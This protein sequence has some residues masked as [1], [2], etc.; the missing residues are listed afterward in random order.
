M[1]EKFYQKSVEDTLKATLSSSQGLSE[2]E[3]KKR[4]EQ[5]GYNELE[6]IKSQSTFMIFLSQFKDLLVLILIAAAIV[7]MI[8]GELEST[9]VILVVITMNAILGTVQSVKAQKSLESLKQLSTPHT[10]VIRD[11]KTMEIS[12]KELSVG[13]IMLLEAGDVVGAD[14]RII[15]NYTLQVNE[16]A[17]TGEVESV[18][19]EV[20]AIEQECGLGDQKNMVFSSGL[21]TYGRAVCVVTGIGMDT[22][23][24]KIATLMNQTKERKTPLQLTLDDF[25]KKLSI[26]IIAICIL[27]FGLN[28]WQGDAILDALMFAVA[29]AVAAIP[30]ALASIVTIVL[31]MG[32]SQMA[33]ENAIVKNIN[34]VE[35]LGCVSVICSDKTGTL[36]QNK[37]TAQEIYRNHE[38]IKATALKE[39]TP[40]DRMM[41][42]GFAL[43]TDAQTNEQQR[44]GDPTELAL[45]DL[46]EI[47]HID[48]LTTRKKYERIDENPFDSQRKLMSTLQMIDGNATLLLKGACDEILK[49]S[50]KIHLED[51]IHDITEEDKVA[52][53]QKNEAFA[54]NGLRV[55]GFAY[56]NVNHQSISIEDEQELIFIGLISLMDPPRVESKTA[57]EHCLRAGI[58]PIMI[59][60]DHKVTAR[61]IAKTLGIYQQGDLCLEGIEL[62]AMSEEELDEKLASIKVYA[63]VAPE[64]KIRIVN[65]WQKKG[66][67]VAMTGDGVNDAPALK[68]SDIG[69]AMGITGTEVSKDA[70]SMILTDDNFATIVKAVATGRNIYANI[71]NAIIYLLSGNLSG[72]ICVLAAS[73]LGLQVPFLPVHLLFIN[74]VTDSLPA[75]AIGMERSTKDVLKEQ[76]RDP[77][78]GILT[79]ETIK[80][81]GVQGILIAIVTMAAYFIGLKTSWAIATTMAF[82]TLCLARL[83]HGFNCR[84][85]HSLYHIKLSSNPYAIMA[86]IVGFIFLTTILMIPT[87][88]SLFSVTTISYS[89]LLTMYGLAITPTLLIQAYKTAKDLHIIR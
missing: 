73:L 54:E 24:G 50:T 30:E 75:I 39:T 47:Y 78:V 21:V 65:A 81:L 23:I 67:I 76:P 59:T 66:N 31:A 72:I 55:L 25:S 80:Q 68:Q 57:V 15:E 43:C 2:Q 33:K 27:V 8:S 69:I 20:D 60:G 40:L 1:Q 4:Q 52:I 88:H 18:Q 14:A 32:T 19:K 63:R 12:S 64:H 36:T 71:K 9:I 13:D 41:L 35:S 10:R 87:L 48:E 26:G 34:S 46:L 83:F 89:Q 7:S 77:K 3:V 37:M 44:I 84:S 79:K 22:E 38:L 53:L 29:L 28:V 62:D 61:S 6:E 86:F 74:L 49:K 42:L 85:K 56:R 51:G 58:T 45:V 16:S 5:H 17:L 82:S 70:A 11:G